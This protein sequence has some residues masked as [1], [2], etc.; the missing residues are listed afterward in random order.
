MIHDLESLKKSIKIT[1]TG[2]FINV[3]TQAYAT[4]NARLSLAFI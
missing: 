3:K 1:V 2:I 4:V